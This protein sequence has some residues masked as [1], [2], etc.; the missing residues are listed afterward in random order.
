LRIFVVLRS[1]E[2]GAGQ[3]DSAWHVVVALWVLPAIFLSPINGAISNSLPKPRVLMG[4]AAWCLTVTLAFAF[5]DGPWLAAVALLAVGSAVFGP[6]RYALLPA[7]ARDGGL[8]LSR[9]NGWIEM[10]TA[11][12]IV[13]G[14]V[15]G[16]FLYGYPSP[17]LEETLSAS[18]IQM[19]PA[20][21]VLGGLAAPIAASV[22]LSVLALLAAVPV[23]FSSDLCRPEPAGQALVGF[24][25]DTRRILR[26]TET[27][28]L[29]IGLAGLRA[30][31]AAVAGAA[32][33]QALSQSALAESD[34]AFRAL[35]RV[36]VWTM[37]GGAIG[38]L[39][40]G[41]QSHPRRALGLIPFAATGLV[42]TLAWAIG[43]VLPWWM[44]LIVGVLIG[45]VNVPLNAAYQAGV[46]ADAR[47]NAMAVLNTAGFLF[48]TAIALA[49]GG[50]ARF[51]IISPVGQMMLVTILA[52]LATTAAWWKFFRDAFEQV[53]ESMLW[54]IYRV[55][56]QGPGLI[57]F[58]RIGPLLVVANHTS[59][60]DPVWLAKLLP[61]RMT[62]MMT[63]VFY[64][65]PV[66]HW[67][68][69]HV[70]HAIR[71][72][73]STYRH[74]A[75]ELAQAIAA[76]DR[77]E[78]VVIFPEGRMRRKPETRL[79]Q[80]GQGV[81]HILHERP[82]TP[83]VACW[84][85]GGW[86]SYASY[87]GGPPTVNK[88]LDFWRR[89]DVGV[90]EPIPLDPALLADQRATR[91]QL[92]QA[93]LDARRYLGLEPLELGESAEILAFAGDEEE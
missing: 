31:G 41:V 75:P 93:C 62:P 85:E 43:H 63:S 27:R 20:A 33:A 79:R 61:R 9:V 21:A 34:D 50:L 11:T 23:H 51:Q 18:D 39:L 40:A 47:G 56:G 1:A 4:A 32:V 68:M 13:A 12:A 52:V 26:E 76:L 46:P 53:V 29:L 83:V 89:I 44:Y 3:R 10:G 6:T 36:A 16:G 70:I 77:G 42:M 84:I 81:W 30:L 92:M 25:R 35:L 19:P 28:D 45:L 54:P 8:P 59:W 91:R 49:M 82:V 86:G 90:S 87:A 66:L 73:V 64:D 80:F 88:R 65:L 7:A 58:P 38:S 60:F 5:T 72:Q 55:H 69:V 67:L 14:M 78:C 37:V 48:M 24:F 71:V 2:Y 57:D 74:E 17:D 15:L 22:A